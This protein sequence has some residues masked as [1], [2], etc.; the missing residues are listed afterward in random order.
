M[1]TNWKL[2]IN[3]YGAKYSWDS[4]NGRIRDEERRTARAP[5]KHNITQEPVQG[6][7]GAQTE[8][9]D[10]A[11]Y[12]AMEITRTEPTHANPSPQG[13]AVLGHKSPFPLSARA[14]LAG[15]TPALD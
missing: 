9:K 3:H 11:S 2:K 4:K 6:I 5:Q 13:A 15:R 8:T 12:G 10:Q 7:M 14:S 1:A